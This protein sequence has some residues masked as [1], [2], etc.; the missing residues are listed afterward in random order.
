MIEAIPLTILGLFTLTLVFAFV[1]QYLLWRR[2]ETIAAE[3]TG[4]TAPPADWLEDRLAPYARK[5]TRR[6]A[7]L[8]YGVPVL[9][10]AVMITILARD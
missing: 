8:I 1:R 9:Y 4:G 10:V 5:M 3:W 7:A 2:R 6:L